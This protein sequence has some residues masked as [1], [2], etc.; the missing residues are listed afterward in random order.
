MTMPNERLRSVIQTQEFLVELGRNSDLPESIR[1]E[2][3]R[4]LRHYPSAQQMRQV[5]RG[6]E[7]LAAISPWE[8]LF[9][10]EEE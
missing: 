9:A 6:E 8:P 10:C 2:A 3:R 5:G 4:L 7:R 1:N